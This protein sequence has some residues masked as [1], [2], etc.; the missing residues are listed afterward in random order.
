MS[1]TNNQNKPMA[2]RR[3][4]VV[5]T[6]PKTRLCV[7]MYQIV[8]ERTGEYIGPEFRMPGN[9]LAFLTDQEMLLVGEVE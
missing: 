5:R 9:L 2:G 1:D 3:V 8:D 4:K 7:R 6:E